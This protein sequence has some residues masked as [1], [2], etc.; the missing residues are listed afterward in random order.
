[1]SSPLLLDG[2]FIA[3]YPALARRLGGQPM[4][5]IIVQALWFR[6]DRTDDTTTMSY[7]A[8]GE[9]VGCSADTAKRQVKWLVE[10][11][12]MTKS[13]ASSHDATSVFAISEAALTSA[14][15]P[16][17]RANPPAPA[18]ESA[19]STRRIRTIDQG[20]LPSSADRPIEGGRIRTV[21][22][23]NLPSSDQGK[24][25]SSTTSKNEKNTPPQSDGFKEFWGEFPDAG[26]KGRRADC[27]RLWLS[28]SI[29]E[30]HTA[31]HML[32]AYKTSVLWVEEGRVPSPYQWLEN[33]NWRGERP[34]QV[35]KRVMLTADD[36]RLSD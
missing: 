6:R 12:F 22:E 14:D 5:A 30:R 7:E 24:L 9:M 3:Y 33:E 19:S 26:Y 1:V 34:K 20:N 32:Q 25:P 17:R 4:R 11:G 27:Q 13:R 8:L 15:A 10:N 36:I 2:E 35:K 16:K 18:D 29:E 21:E 31:W 23:G 28:M